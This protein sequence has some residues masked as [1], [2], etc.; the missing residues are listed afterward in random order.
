MLH[1]LSI[2]NDLDVTHEDS[3][4][5][6]MMEFLLCLPDATFWQILREACQNGGE[7][8]EY[9][10]KLIE[11]KFWP[12]WNSEGSANSKFVEPDVFLRFEKVHVIIEAK[13]SD[14]CGQSNGQWKKELIAYQNQ[15]GLDSLLPVYLIALGGNGTRMDNES[16]NVGGKN[17]TIIKCSWLKLHSVLVQWQEMLSEGERRAVD[18][19]LLASELFGILSYKWIDGRDWV[20]QYRINLPDSFDDIHIQE[21]RK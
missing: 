19:L 6:T 4:T 2:K 8:P 5:S 9:V 11:Y 21:M 10:G 3:I 20:S 1:S 13:H 16:K 14:S 15:Y 18:S 7:L 12:K 17:R